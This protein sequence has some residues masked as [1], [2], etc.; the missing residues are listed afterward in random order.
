MRKRD[1][2]AA[3]IG[4]AAALLLTGGIAWAAIPGADGVIQA[5]YDSGG[6]V[7]VVA[8]LPCPRG[9]TPLAWN[10]QGPAGT[11]GAPGESAY[12]TWLDLG[13]AGT[14]QD[15]IDSLQGSAGTDGQDGNLALA[16][17]SCPQG[18]FVT[19][20]DH[21]GNI[22]CDGSPPPP[23][24]QDVGADC[25]PLNLVP[26]ADLHNCDLHGL[27][28]GYGVDLHG[29]N[30][31]GANLNFNIMNA[32]NLSGASLIGAQLEGSHL[33]FDTNLSGANLSGAVLIYTRLDGA[34]L[35]NVDLSDAVLFGANLSG[36]NL[37]GADLSGVAWTDT[38]CPDGTNS[39][40]NGFTCEGHLF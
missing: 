15:F 2:K 28:G 29:A 30:L 9:Y 18:Q 16:G 23:P 22:V 7:K 21:S 37:S 17:Q 26:G 36:A 5:C 31:N 8:A 3:V 10:Q 6:N 34:D 11:D 1:F 38:T 14:E 27:L 19:G 25:E 32:Y 24:P 40:S 39:N 33:L 4:G 20:F 13:N 12:R 35:S